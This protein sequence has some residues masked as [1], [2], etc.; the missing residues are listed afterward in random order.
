MQSS[1][2]EVFT[3]KNVLRILLFG[4]WNAAHSL[5]H[6]WNKHYNPPKLLSR[7]RLET[8]S[9][10]E[11]QNQ[12]TSPWPVPPLAAWA[13]I[14]MNTSTSQYTC[15]GVFMVQELIYLLVHKPAKEQQTKE[16]T[17]LLPEDDNPELRSLQS[18]PLNKAGVTGEPYNLGQP[19][20]YMI[21]TSQLTLRHCMSEL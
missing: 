8:T 14:C 4:T 6:Q 3:I 2:W 9:K 11:S 16:E 12:G 10:A 13:S 18:W 7:M 19:S 15:R 17:D 1:V 20:V 21:P 5:G